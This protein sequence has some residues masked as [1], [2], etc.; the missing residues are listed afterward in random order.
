MS[1]RRLIRMLGVP[2]MLV[3][4]GCASKPVL[5]SQFPSPMAEHIRAHERVTES[6][7]GG[8]RTEIDLGL[9]RP[10]VF[11][12]PLGAATP[13][14]VDVLV[15]FHGAEYVAERAATLMQPSPV[16]AVVNL[17]SGSSAY[18]RPF[19]DPSLFPVILRA[20]G[21]AAAKANAGDEDS[22]AS[23]AAGA[24]AGSPAIRS[25]TIS[26]WSAGYG[27]VRA[28]LPVHGQRVDALFLLDGL[29]TDYVPEGQLLHDGGG[30]NTTKLQPFLTM[31]KRAVAGDACMVVTHS[32][33]FPG[34]YASTT[35]TAAW[36][37][38]ELGLSILPV[39]EWGPVGMQGIGRA[40]QGRFRIL[41]FAGNTAPDHVDHLHGLPEFLGLCA[42]NGASASADS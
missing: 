36:L 33:V 35:E 8:I 6:A 10:V 39:L 42:P 18:E 9:S 13:D 22:A 3:V 30:L 20:A 21:E 29:H 2:V 17:G 38:S 12:V 4:S 19:A 23:G 7:A 28:T 24:A 16:V 40:E 5:Q 1:M 25:V 14:S 15:H 26:A 37:A 27:A 41:A 31:A 11:H 32:A 34:T